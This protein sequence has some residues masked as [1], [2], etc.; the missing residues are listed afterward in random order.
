MTIKQTYKERKKYLSMLE[1]LADTM[2]KVME[3]NGTLAMRSWIRHVD[4]IKPCNTA[5]CVCGHHVLIGNLTPF[6][7]LKTND[8]LLIS[9]SRRNGK[10][11]HFLKS[12]AAT[13]SS[14]LDLQE[15]DACVDEMEDCDKSMPPI[16]CSIY[17]ATKKIRMKCAIN[18]RLFN[19]AEL[20]TFRHLTTMSTPEDAHIYIKAVIKRLR[21]RWEPWRNE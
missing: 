17:T 9:G 18:T 5:A 6:L 2:K 8:P 11:Y 4:R 1:A 16:S 7:G 14:K 13:I 10:T 21:E 20:K 19:Q 12:R 15:I 3:N